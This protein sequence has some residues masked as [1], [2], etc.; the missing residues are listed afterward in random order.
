MGV[1][2]SPPATPSAVA[3]DK[4]SS[5]T[6]TH[7]GI[8]EVR[9]DACGGI[10]LSG[11][12][13]DPAPSPI[14]LTMA[15][16]AQG[17]LRVRRPAV[18]RSCLAAARGD[19]PQSRPDLRGQEGFVE[20]GWDEALALAAAEIARVRTSHGNRA[21]FGGSYGWSSAGRFH[22]AQSQVHRF[23]NSVGGYVPSDWRASGPHNIE[24]HGNPN[25]LTLDIGASGLSQGCI[26]QTCLVDVERYIGPE[27]PPTPFRLPEFVA[28][29]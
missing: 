21:I 13:R 22:H 1:R 27:L 15:A 29:P 25:V 8:Y 24:K 7:W 10:A 17:P 2:E 18:R 6:A 26:A 4:P 16:A 14:G 20:I 23:L 12:A 9:H 3:G 11:F 28:R 5:Y 19:L